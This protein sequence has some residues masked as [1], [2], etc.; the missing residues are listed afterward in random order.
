MNTDY[1][2]AIDSVLRLLF[3]NICLLSIGDTR[4]SFDRSPSYLERREMNG[5][6]NLRPQLYES[7]VNA[8]PHKVYGSSRRVTSS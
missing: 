4:Q 1:Q 7:P 8:P 3:P 2:R 6:S 5:H